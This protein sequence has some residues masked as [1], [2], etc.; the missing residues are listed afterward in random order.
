[1][2]EKQTIIFDMDGTLL[3]TE[4]YYRRY[5]KEAAYDCGYEMTDEQALAMRSMGRP[6][7]ARKIK[8]Y[9]GTEAAYQQI[10]N[11]R[12]ELMSAKLRQDGIPLK[13]FVKEV[14]TELKRRG[15]RLVIA[16]ATDPQRT[17]QYLKE[18]G[19]YSYFT[20]IICATMVERGKP[21]PDIYLYA[22][23]ELGIEPQKAFAVE[24]SPNGV[25]S[26][27]QAGCRVIMIP[28]QTRPEAE[29]RRLLYRC[30][31]TLEELLT[32]EELNGRNE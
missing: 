9:Y 10:R 19:L 11:R 28:D 23:R 12:M 30:V 16:T 24:D 32:L 27:Y 29:Q 31:N 22:C 25:L 4:R 26:A 5:W 21:A 14:L 13:P 15:H 1:M 18:A 7:A 20:R 8:E 17:E 3:D 6:F 2:A